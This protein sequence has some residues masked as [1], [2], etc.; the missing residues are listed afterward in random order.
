VPNPQAN[1]DHAA[2][3]ISVHSPGVVA[4]ADG[5]LMSIPFPHVVFQENTKTSTF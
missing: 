3:P 2:V 4:D 1:L 5:D